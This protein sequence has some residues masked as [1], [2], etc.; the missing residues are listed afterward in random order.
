MHR[1]YFFILPEKDD[2]VS[3]RI[4]IR[5]HKHGNMT[6]TFRQAFLNIVHHNYS[7]MS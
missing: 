6:T 7:K 3:K 5:Y 2:D 1:E 4:E